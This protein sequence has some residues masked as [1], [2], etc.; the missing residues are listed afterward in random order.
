MVL[1]SRIDQWP[2]AVM[3]AM[4]YGVPPVVSR[5]GGMPEMVDRGVAG[6]LLADH[7]DESLRDAIAGLL[8]D[9]RRRHALGERARARVRV[10]YDARATAN[11]LLDVI[12]DVAVR[13]PMGV[14]HP[15]IQA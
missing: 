6:L 9:P 8:D 4:S 5:V 3:E 12:R 11:R 10:R 7:S 1:P 2:N 13:R 15:E 14:R